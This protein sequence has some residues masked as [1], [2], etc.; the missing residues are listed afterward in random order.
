MIIIVLSCRRCEGSAEGV[1]KLGR[2]RRST[3]L[4]AHRSN[5]KLFQE[6][7]AFA[8]RGAHISL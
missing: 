2:S 7:L 6:K 4:V 5:N 1:A 3:A 8:L